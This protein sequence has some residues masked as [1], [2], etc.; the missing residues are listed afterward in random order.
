MF[1]DEL[2]NLPDIISAVKAD[3]IEGSFDIFFIFFFLL[4][5]SRTS[6]KSVYNYHSLKTKLTT[7]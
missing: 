5:H 1:H 4:T 7:N 3:N 6:K 2:K